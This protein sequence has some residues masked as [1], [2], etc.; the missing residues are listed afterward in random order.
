MTKNNKP[1]ISIVIPVYKPEKEVFE[2][3]KDML[4]AQTIQDFELVENWNMPEAKSMNTGIRR[5]TGDII[6]TLAQDCVPEDEFWLEKIT[7]PLE[8][9]AIVATVSKLYLPKEHWQKNSFL[10]KAFTIND[11]NTRTPEMDMRGCA[12]RKKDLEAIGLISENPNIIGVDVD[13][14]IK[15][16]KLGRF[17][18]PD[19]RVF[20][21]HKLATFRDCI[22][23][24]FKYSRGNGI[25]VKEYGSGI[26]T[27]WIRVLRA[28]PIL[29]IISMIYRFP[30]REHMDLLPLHIIFAPV[31]NIINVFGFWV[32]F[33]SHK[34]QFDPNPSTQTKELS[35]I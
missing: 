7:K 20:H 13:M 5:A 21:L 23:L 22:N 29:G 32:G 6:V 15:L 26:G 12:F 3:L 25:A 35:K 16:K 27:S 14:Q 24:I 28:T 19:T 10:V 18:Y 34:K 30:F 33:L 11:L 17:A 31:H 8:N 4:K 9:K 1:K 2:K